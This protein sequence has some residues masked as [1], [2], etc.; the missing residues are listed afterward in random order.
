MET[1]KQLVIASILVLAAMLAASAWVWFGVFDPN[2]LLHSGTVGRTDLA[3][4]K[5]F[6]L[7]FA[8]MVIV[9]GSIIWAVIPTV[10]PRRRNLNRSPKYYASSWAAFLI[11]MSAMHA[12]VVLTAFNKVPQSSA[13]PAL[14]FAIAMVIQ[15]NYMSKSRSTFF[16]GIRTAWTLS[17]EL[18]WTKTH[19]L[20]GRIYMGLGALVILLAF[21]APKLAFGTFAFGIAASIVILLPYSYFVWRGDPDKQT[22]TMPGNGRQKSIW[23]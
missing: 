16:V 1:R 12:Y 18:S 13:L 17:S 11:V 7:L 4:T 19:R 3:V 21:V 5:A 10:E 8:P 20:G 2:L 22:G 6:N 15:G 23:R 9:I 14:V